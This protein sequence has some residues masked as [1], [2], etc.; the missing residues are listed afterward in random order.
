M[1]QQPQRLIV[2]LHRVTKLPR[3]S[4]TRLDATKEW[5]VDS[6][7]QM[8]LGEAMSEEDWAQ[9]FSPLGRLRIAELWEERLLPVP[10][11]PFLHVFVLLS[12]GDY[13]LSV[14]R[15]PDRIEL[16]L[17][18]A[19]EV[20][21]YAVSHRPPQSAEQRLFVRH[22][23]ES[24]LAQR[25]ELGADD[26]LCQLPGGLRTLLVTEAARAPVQGPLGRITGSCGGYDLLQNNCRTFADRIITWFS[27]PRP[28][29]F[30]EEK[31]WLE[32]FK[33]AGDAPEPLNHSTTRQRT[34]GGSKDVAELQ[35]VFVPSRL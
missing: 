27:S 11:G 22:R 17:G 20:A 21:E 4:S 5:H 9:R 3:T 16:S 34:V 29:G 8:P 31:Q 28:V 30:A 24:R 26:S 19:S 33:P 14:E 15:F 10:H 32:S 13:A 1:D 18:R 35:P 12:D 6:W 23:R 25:I 7:M 2:N